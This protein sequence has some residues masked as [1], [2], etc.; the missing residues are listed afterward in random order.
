MKCHT[1]RVAK[2]A[3]L[4]SIANG[5]RKAEFI[6]EYEALCEKYSCYLQ[7]CSSYLDGADVWFESNEGWRVDDV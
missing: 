4:K 6:V 1:T 5:E 3:H 2:A 7:S